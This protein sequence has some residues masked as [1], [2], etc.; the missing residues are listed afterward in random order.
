MS[1]SLRAILIG[2]RLR[3]RLL[4]SSVLPNGGLGRGVDFSGSS[5]RGGKVRGL[6]RVRLFFRIRASSRACRAKKLYV[7]ASTCKG[8]RVLRGSRKFR[9]VGRSNIEVIT[10]C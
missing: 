8:V 9:V 3:D 4:V 10:G 7:G 1:V 6:T 5:L 2:K